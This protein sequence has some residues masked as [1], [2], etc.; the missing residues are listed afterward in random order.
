MQ[1]WESKWKGGYWM[2]GCWGMGEAVGTERARDKADREVSIICRMHGPIP[3]QLDGWQY[4]LGIKR[5]VK[6]NVPHP[7]P[8]G[9]T[10]CTSFW[11]VA[12]SGF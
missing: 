7:H 8:C 12:H 2:M 11:V 5:C 10:E 3:F 4:V 6:T 9:M 1:A